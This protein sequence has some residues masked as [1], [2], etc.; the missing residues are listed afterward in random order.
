M[1]RYRRSLQRRGVAHEYARLRAAPGRHHDGDGGFQQ[2]NGPFFPVYLCGQ[3]WGSHWP[4]S[5]WCYDRPSITCTSGALLLS[6]VFAALSRPLEPP[7]EWPGTDSLDLYGRV[8]DA[9][10]HVDETTNA[11]GVL[12]GKVIE[13]VM[14]GSVAEGGNNACVYR[15]PDLFD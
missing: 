15:H 13:N 9:Q 8:H 2:K 3:F 1:Q 10:K 14:V 4:R 7:V 5:R 12:L 11:D 6:L